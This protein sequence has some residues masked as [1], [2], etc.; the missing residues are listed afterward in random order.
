M[1]LQNQN[2]ML[3]G[4]DEEKSLS[5]IGITSGSLEFDPSSTSSRFIDLSNIKF[6]KML[7]CSK[8]GSDINADGYL[9]FTYNS[10]GIEFSQSV[11]QEAGPGS[12]LSTFV[13]QYAEYLP[14]NIRGITFTGNNGTASQLYYDYN[15][16]FFA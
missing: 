13:R 5:L 4:S 1:F 10:N 2:I 12:L 11:Y 7:L 8:D 3:Y 6:K 16:A 15:I 14:S 9:Q